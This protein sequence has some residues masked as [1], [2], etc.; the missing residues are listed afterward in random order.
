MSPLTP[1]PA[2]APRAKA[3]RLCTLGI[4]ALFAGTNSAR[5]DWLIIPFAG[6][7]FGGDATSSLSLEGD[8]GR[9]AVFGVATAWMTRQI[10]GLEGEFLYGPG[11]FQR[12]QGLAVGGSHI[13]SA[14]GGLVVALPVSVT[15]ESLRPY[16][17]AGLG[18][19]HASADY[20]FDI[21]GFGESQRFASFHVGGGAIGFI[22]PDVGVRFD[23]RHTNSL[24]RVDDE[25]TGAPRP[26]LR[27]WRFSVGVVVLVG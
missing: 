4:L 3:G 16:A 19:M 11:F 26:R 13:W 10:F 5:A 17:T 21:F 8:Q 12:G 14:T 9:K 6:P 23:L 7:T 20:S 1:T 18:T 24:N 22:S 2:G 27:F 15:R 25:V